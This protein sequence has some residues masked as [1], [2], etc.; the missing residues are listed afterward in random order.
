MLSSL[1]SLYPWIPVS[2]CPFAVGSCA[3]ARSLL[4]P[5]HLLTSVQIRASS[6][7][8]VQPWNRKNLSENE[9][10][11]VNK[12]KWPSNWGRWV[13][14]SPLE[15]GTY[16]ADGAKIE[17]FTEWEYWEGNTSLR[18]QEWAFRFA[19]HLWE[20]IL[21]FRVWSTWCYSFQSAWQAHCEAGEP[22]AQQE[23]EVRD[24]ERHWYNSG[25]DLDK[26]CTLQLLK[27]L[28]KYH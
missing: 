16:S 11:G 24:G 2:R 13:W 20:L 23:R 19:R 3:V 6:S 4:S 14:P 5:P 22:E 12:K 8:S 10:I 9:N 7:G 1:L 25:V 26:R 17:V 27:I 21:G 15:R 28:Q 18:L